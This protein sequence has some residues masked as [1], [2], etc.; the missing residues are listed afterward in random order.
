MRVQ[1]DDF[2]VALYND[3]HLKNRAIAATFIGLVLPAALLTTAGVPEKPVYLAMSLLVLPLM[4]CIYRVSQR[5]VPEVLRRVPQTP[6][7]NAN[8]AIHPRSQAGRS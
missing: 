7:A 6:S 3:A 1:V 5:G 8:I 2:F 4:F